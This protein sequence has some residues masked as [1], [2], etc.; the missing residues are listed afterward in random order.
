MMDEFP[1]E[2]IFDSVGGDHIGVDV[3]AVGEEAE[4]HSTIKKLIEDARSFDEEYLSPMRVTADAFYKGMLPSLSPDDEA[5]GDENGTPDRSTIVSTD[6]RDVVMAIM[7]SLVRIFTSNEH[8]VYFS[9][10]SPES[11]EMAEQATDYISYVYWEDNEG[12]MTTYSILMDA[13]NK[14]NAIVEW[15][16]KETKH[17]EYCEYTSLDAEQLQYVL[18]DVGNAEVEVLNVSERI[19]DDGQTPVSD[20]ALKLTRVDRGT[21]VECVPPDEFRISRFAKSIKK[22]RLVGRERYVTVSYL[23]SLGYSLELIERCKGTGAYVDHNSEERIQRNPGYMDDHRPEDEV[24]YGKFWVRVDGDGDGIDELRH[25]CVIGDTIV[26]DEPCNSVPMAMGSPDPEPHAANGHS[27]NEQ[28]QDLQRIKTNV[29]RSTLDSLAASINPKVVVTESMVN[30]SDVLSDSVGQVVRSKAPGHYQPIVTPFAG[31]PAI[32]VLTYMDGVGQRRTGISEAS[33]GLDPK[34]LQSTAVKGVDMVITGAQERIELIARILAETIFKDMFKGLLEEVTANPNRKRTIQ[35][36]GK[37]VSVNPDNF[38]PTMRVKVNPSI[39]RGSDHDR[40]AMLGQ[41]AQ[42]QM[43][44]IEK[45]GVANPVVT[46]AHYLNTVQDMMSLAGMKNFDRY[47]SHPTPEQIQGMAQAMNK[48]DPATLLAQAEA[49]KVKA[50]TV[51]KIADNNLKTVKMNM[52]DDFRRDKLEADTTIKAAEVGLDAVSI[53]AD[54][55]KPR[56]EIN[57]GYGRPDQIS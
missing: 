13:C 27:V 30:M 32:N 18:S 50:D 9:P 19:D 53:I 49:E 8:P 48:P 25:V 37:W 42:Q 45:L 17:V 54:M 22:S 57:N 1:T 24:L 31:D 35:L 2:R 44:I 21:C 28:V 29:L 26:R 36:R 39:G 38:D 46:P 55:N 7:P 5:D 4:H 3:D 12:F 56:E 16:T 10:N 34:A 14:G 23:V 11:V 6:V 40:F 41:I 33:R 20:I 51:G 43:M 47:F 15:W 52:D